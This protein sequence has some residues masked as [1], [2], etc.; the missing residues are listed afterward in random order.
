MDVCARF[1][2]AQKTSS[3]T[4]PL[5]F[6]LLERNNFNSGTKSWFS[7]LAFHFHFSLHFRPTLHHFMCKVFPTFLMNNESVQDNLACFV[8]ADKHFP[9]SQNQFT[10]TLI[11]HKYVAWDSLTELSKKVHQ[12]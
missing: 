8:S 9:K 10:P 12:K 7:N 6:P 1:T 11:H 5:Y 3:I 4:F 2:L